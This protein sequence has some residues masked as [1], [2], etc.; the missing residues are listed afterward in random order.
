MRKQQREDVSGCAWPASWPAAM[1]ACLDVAVYIAGLA[2][3][4]LYSA[5]VVLI[6]AASQEVAGQ[7]FAKQCQQ[8]RLKFCCS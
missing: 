4:S 6:A 2:I 1:S 7:H 8:A 3:V 5:R